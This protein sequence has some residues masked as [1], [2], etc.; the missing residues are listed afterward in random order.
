MADFE[1]S[2]YSYTYRYQDKLLEEAK[3]FVRDWL[4]NQDDFEAAVDWLFG[5]DANVFFK[6][7]RGTFAF[8]I[9][10]FIIDS[11]ENSS[12]EYDEDNDE[13]Q[14]VADEDQ[15]EL[16]KSD[17]YDRVRDYFDC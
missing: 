3:I 1:D 16:D 13:S 4:T 15:D 5:D 8:D 12:D 2:I 10:A 7:Q 6:S 9:V 17:I 14:E 11:F